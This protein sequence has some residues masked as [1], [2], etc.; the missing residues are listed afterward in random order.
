MFDTSS[1][2]LAANLVTTGTVTLSYPQGRQRGDYLLGYAHKLNGPSATY[3]APVDFTLTFNAANITL[4]WN[5]AQTLLAGTAFTVELDR[6]GSEVA[7]GLHS[8]ALTVMTQ[9]AGNPNISTA[10]VLGKPAAVAVG[11]LVYASFGSPAAAVTTAICN[12][13]DVA[14][15]GAAPGTALTINGSLASIVSGVTRAVL[16]VPR[17][18]TVTSAANVSAFTIRVTGLDMYGRTMS[19]DITGPNATTVTGN[20]A[21]YVITAVAVIG[22]GDPGAISVGTGNALGIPFVLPSAGLVLREFLNGATAGSAGTFTPQANVT[23]TR[24]TG[25]VRGTYTPNASNLPDGTRGFAALIAVLPTD[26]VLP[27]A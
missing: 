7:Q 3:L 22:A 8:Q 24:T 23:P 15:S 6:V 17:N 12:A 9:L 19:E 10:G 4:T 20:K 13:V 11:G 1:L 21:F 18:V 27:Q 16:D 14:T 5:G 25:D 26:V 2:T